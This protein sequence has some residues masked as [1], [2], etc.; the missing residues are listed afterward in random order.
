MI[1]N[2]TNFKIKLS[3]KESYKHQ[4]ADTWGTRAEQK[5]QLSGKEMFRLVMAKNGGEISERSIY[6]KEYINPNDSITDL[7]NKVSTT[8]NNNAV[9]MGYN[10]DKGATPTVSAKQK[11]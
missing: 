6:S 1:A 9:S 7:F 3:K 8:Q 5:P 2:S 4:V 11:L 10:K